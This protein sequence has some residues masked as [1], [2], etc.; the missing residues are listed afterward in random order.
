MIIVTHSSNVTGEIYPIAEIGKLAHE[1]GILMMSD[2]A[3]SAGH[4][5]IDMEKM[6]L[7]I[8]VVIKGCLEIV[9]LVVFVWL[10]L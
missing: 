6:N 9:E 4:L 8:L 10:N 2:I 1:N 7:D 5:L 3:Q